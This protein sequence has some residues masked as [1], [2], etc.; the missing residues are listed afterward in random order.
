[1][2]DIKKVRRDLFEDFIIK[3]KHLDPEIATFINQLRTNN[4]KVKDGVN[5]KIEYHKPVDVDH[6]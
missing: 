1:M 5:L 4:W 2:E 6:R 3:K